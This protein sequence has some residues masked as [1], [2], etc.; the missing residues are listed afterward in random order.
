MSINAKEL[1]IG[2]IT[3]LH[4]GDDF[5]GNENRE[6]DAID[7]NVAFEE[8]ERFSPIPLTPEILEKCG[9]EKRLHGN[10]WFVVCGKTS[11]NMSGLFIEIN[12]DDN[13]SCS[14]GQ[15]NHFSHQFGEY[16]H[17]HQLQNLYYSL[18]GTELP[19]NKILEV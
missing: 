15:L 16:K 6:L 17:L 1:R 2:N 9:F 10:E 12:I 4:R 7:I 18:T 11:K 5:S 8:P 14:I 19:I 3:I 13:Y